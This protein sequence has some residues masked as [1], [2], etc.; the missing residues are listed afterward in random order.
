MT[1]PIQPPAAPP[2][3][4]DKRQTAGLASPST[5]PT[6]VRWV[7]GLLLAGGIVTAVWWFGYREHGR[8]SRRSGKRARARE[9]ARESRK[10]RKKTGKSRPKKKR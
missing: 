3:A 9:S 8:K 5:W 7:V 1:D 6:W 10:P 2:S 4:I